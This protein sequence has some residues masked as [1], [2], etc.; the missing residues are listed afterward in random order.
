[1][2]TASLQGTYSSEAYSLT[3]FQDWSLHNH[4]RTHLISLHDLLVLLIVCLY[5]VQQW[6]SL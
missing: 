3:T 2:K 1:M 4:C 6:D 5:E